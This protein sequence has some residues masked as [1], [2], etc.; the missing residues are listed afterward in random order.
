M[1][2]PPTGIG[3]F[4]SW[5]MKIQ[6]KKVETFE[7]TIQ[8]RPG[9][10]ANA[11]DYTSFLSSNQ[12]THLTDDPIQIV[13]LAKYLESQAIQRGFSADPVVTANVIVSLNG[14]LTDALFIK[15]L[16]AIVVITY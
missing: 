3:G 13:Q 7:L 11:V 15:Y 5:R 12:L 8:D 10:Q 6:S 9:G 4:F 14:H 16:Q 2:I 1:N